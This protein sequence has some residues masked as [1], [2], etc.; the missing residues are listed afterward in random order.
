MKNQSAILQAIAT[1]NRTRRTGKVPIIDM[2]DPSMEYVGEDTGGYVS[3]RAGTRT[4]PYVTKKMKSDV[5]IT[6]EELEEAQAAGFGDFENLVLDMWT[7]RLGNDLARAVFQSDSSF[8]SATRLN[9]MLRSQD[10]VSKLTTAGGVIIP[11]AG[12]KFGPG[13]F[14]VLKDNVPEELAQT[15]ALRWIYNPR[16]E[17]RWLASLQ[18]KATAVGD[19]ALTNPA[20][21]RPSGIPQ[22]ITPQIPATMG[23]SGTP[24]AVA[25]DGDGTMTVTVDTVLGGA[26]AGHAGRKIKITC[27]PTG[28]WEICDVTWASPNN[29]ILTTSALGQQTISTTVGDYVVKLYDET[30]V[31]LCDPK[32]IIMV[33]CRSWRSYRRFNQHWDRIEITTYIEWAVMAPLVDRMVKVTGL[34]VPPYA[35]WT[36]TGAI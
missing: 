36:E 29:K 8:N 28:K 13:M 24:D 3:N 10:G 19:Q 2:T 31:Y 18:L 11:A 33:L 15:G 9:R 17:E 26:A 23:A 34:V 14:T 4:V 16:I 6:T 35:T 7:M 32:S 1:Y 12:K 27:I 25:D 22:I 5:L 30:E 21:F 20:T